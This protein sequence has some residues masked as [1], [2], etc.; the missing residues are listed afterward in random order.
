MQGCHTHRGIMQHLNISMLAL[1]PGFPFPDIVSQQDK[2]WNRKPRF[3]ASGMPHLHTDNATPT[4]NNV[5][6]FVSNY[7]GTPIL[8]A[9]S[10]ILL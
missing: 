5:I 4:G 3:K 1:N 8:Y 10:Y 6:T 2:I 7:R 9:V